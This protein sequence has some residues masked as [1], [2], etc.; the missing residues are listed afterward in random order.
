MDY[1]LSLSDFSY[2]NLSRIKE[3]FK[4]GMVFFSS[5]YSPHRHL[6]FEERWGRGKG[7]WLG[8][9]FLLAYEW[10]Q[11]S[12]QGYLFTTRWVAAKIL[13]QTYSCREIID[14]FLDSG[15]GIDR[16]NPC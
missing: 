13:S 2:H 4:T 1:R 11:G 6:F 3:L 5:E 15:P 9:G 12:T 10:H 8:E 7:M 16:Y 14:A